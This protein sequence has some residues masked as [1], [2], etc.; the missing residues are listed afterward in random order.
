MSVPVK[1]HT[2]GKVGRRRSHHALK[3]TNMLACTNCKAPVLAHH[4]C[5]YCGAVQTRKVRA[6]AAGTTNEKAAAPATKE[7][8][9]AEEAVV[10]DEPASDESAETVD[11]EAEAGETVTETDESPEAEPAKS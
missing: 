10:E 8:P 2:K 9:K 5:G 4:V 11:E 6:V 1:H 3:A 7:E